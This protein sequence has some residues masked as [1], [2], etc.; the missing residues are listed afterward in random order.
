MSHLK[1]GKLIQVVGTPRSGT[2]FLSV[3]LSLCPNCIGY[4]ELAAS[5]PNWKFTIKQ[6]LQNWQYV[7]DCTT[8]GFLPKAVVKDS[9]KLYIPQ[10]VE[11]SRLKCAEAFGYEP[12]AHNF[13][14][15]D[16]MAKNWA[17]E[18]NPLTI[19]AEELFT[20]GNMLKIWKHCFQGHEPFPGQKVEQLLKQQI[21]RMNPEVVFGK[22]VL[23][24]RE[25]EF[26]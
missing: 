22:D 17:R 26:V 5:G 10:D 11:Q 20:F 12:D 24:G 18:W 1:Q 21:Q 7:A 19:P 13:H 4:H 23:V 8:Y 16:K 9:I 6:A 2:A 15:L 3:M 25:H 14:A